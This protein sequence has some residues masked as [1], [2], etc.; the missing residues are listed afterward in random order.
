MC[1]Y[2]HALLIESRVSRDDDDEREREN[3]WNGMEYQKTRAFHI[4]LAKKRLHNN[5]YGRREREKFPLFCGG[6]DS[7]L[8]RSK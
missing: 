5:G 6:N 3:E 8:A 1:V 2:T 4:E 7:N